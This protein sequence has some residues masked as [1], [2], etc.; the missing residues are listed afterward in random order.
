MFGTWR[1]KN[2]KVQKAFRLVTKELE[3][4]KTVIREGEIMTYRTDLLTNL[5]REV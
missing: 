4:R 1:H 5:L 3:W 2:V